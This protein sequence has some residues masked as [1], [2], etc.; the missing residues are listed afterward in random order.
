MKKF[1]TNSIGICIFKIFH[2]FFLI[3]LKNVVG[4][5]LPISH[6]YG[7]SPPTATDS[8]TPHGVEI[9]YTGSSPRLGLIGSTSARERLKK[10]MRSKP[11]YPRFFVSAVPSFV[12]QLQYPRFFFW[13]P[14]GTRRIERGDDVEPV[15]DS[16]VRGG[17][18]NTD[19]T[20]D[21]LGHRQHDPDETNDDRAAYPRA[22][23][24][25][26][27]DLLQPTTTTALRVEKRAETIREHEAADKR[28]REGRTMVTR[29]IPGESWVEVPLGAKKW[30]IRHKDGKQLLRLD[31]KIG[32]IRHPLPDP[33]VATHKNLNKYKC[34]CLRAH[35]HVDLRGPPPRE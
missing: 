30:V 13:T 17:L 24:P 33:T 1:A 21:R 31:P 11:R 10:I 3:F 2:I 16:D 27:T 28:A 20:H 26:R 4:V 34:N 29:Q 32:D 23:R 19:G 8:K 25:R 12:T 7:T 14:A 5:R 35:L 9:I 15:G 18:D 6:F 22:H